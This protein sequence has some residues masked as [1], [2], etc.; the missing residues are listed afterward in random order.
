MAFPCFRERQKLIPKN[1]GFGTRRLPLETR[2]YEVY[3]QPNV[4]LVDI[5]ETPIERITPAGVKT[6]DA[7]YGFDVIIY[8]TG[9]DAITG[10]FDRID[11]RGVDGR[12]LKEEWAAGPQTYL[13]VLVPGFPNLLMVMGPHT[14]LGNFPRAAEYS[15]EWVTGLVRH[16]RE[17]GQTRIDATQAGKARWTEHVKAMGQGL[18]ANEIDSWMTGINRN[19]EG[20]QT[21]RI[22]RYSGGYP[23]LSRALRRGC[24]GRLPRARAG[25]VRPADQATAPR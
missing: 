17:H 22:M 7:E 23:P 11:I 1:H 18:L 6:S 4:A 3:N 10:S 16:A 21:R 24:G 12:R 13:G 2:Y 15:V 14:G 25:L 19:V 20:K 5:N 8:A 9:F